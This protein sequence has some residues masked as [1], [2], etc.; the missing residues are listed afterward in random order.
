M[1]VSAFNR[2]G[3]RRKEAGSGLYRCIVPHR[4]GDRGVF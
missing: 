2:G 3:G 4:P 1:P